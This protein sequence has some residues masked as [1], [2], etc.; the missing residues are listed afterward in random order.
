M[1]RIA[2]TLLLICTIS[3]HIHAQ[4]IV[5]VD[6]THFNPQVLCPGIYLPVCG[7][8][9]TIPSNACEAFN[10]YALSCWDGI[11]P[12]A[13]PS[14][15]QVDITSEW[16]G[17]TLYLSSTSISASGDPIQTWSW[18]SQYTSFANT[19]DTYLVKAPGDTT[20]LVSL[21]VNTQN[22]CFAYCTYAFDL[23]TAVE[24]PVRRLGIK[25]FPNPVS[26]LVQILFD[27]E[28]EGGL[29]MLMD[30]MGRVEDVQNWSGGRRAEMDVSGLSAGIYILVLQQG[31]DRLI[32]DRLFIAGP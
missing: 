2:T 12:D 10:V 14:G 8:N 30:L 6:S 1:F 16:S 5:C 24:Q 19:E 4:E 28:E 31:N 21:G 17:D 18:D 25:T 3:I 27:E 9:G 13:N 15:C 23:S 26:G 7:C 11:C 29:I 22:G 20:F 32:L